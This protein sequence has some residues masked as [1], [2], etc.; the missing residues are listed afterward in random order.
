MA[1]WA[2]SGG[3]EVEFMCRQLGVSRSGY[4]ARCGR[5]DSDRSSTDQ[6]L[7][8]LIRVIYRWLR[9]NPVVRRVRSELARLGERISPTHACGG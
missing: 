4:Y 5:P 8:S 3:Y 2:E 7:T 1:G 9:G 6:D